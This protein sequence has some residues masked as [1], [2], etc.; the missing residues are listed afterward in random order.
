MVAICNIFVI[1]IFWL[2]WSQSQQFLETDIQS[3][4]KIYDRL[5]DCN[6]MKQ[7]HDY[8]L[9]YK[10]FTDYCLIITTLLID[11]NIVYY[12]YRF[13]RHDDI[14]P[15][16]LLISGVLLR[17]LCQ[18]LNRSPSPDNVIWYDPGFPSIIMNYNVATDF[19]FSGHTLTALIFGIELLK[20]RYVSIKI[21]A[22]IYMLLEISFVL[23]TRSHYFMDIYAAFTTYFM[24]NYFYDNMSFI[25]SNINYIIVTYAAKFKRIKGKFID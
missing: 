1:I 16:I 2:F 15:I 3:T 17:Q 13:L 6:I 22:V 14:K 5:H 25:L 23:V 11:I 21:Y 9:H 10:Q 20:S 24:L 8:M 7:I 18:F 19:F 12:F 4:N